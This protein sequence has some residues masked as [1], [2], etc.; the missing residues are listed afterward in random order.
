MSKNTPPVIEEIKLS[1]LVRDLALSGRS[2][3]EINANAKEKWQELEAFGGW[4]PHQPGQYF[5]RGGK[6]H[7]LVGFSRVQAGLDHGM[8]SGYFVEVPDDAS[9]LRVAC[10]SSNSGRNISQ[11]EQGRVYKAMREGTDRETA[12]AGDPVFAPMKTQE[13]ADFPGIGK[14]RQHV[15][16]CIAIFENPAAIAELI[17]S[18]QISAQVAL[19]AA[20]LCKDENKRLAWIKKA[21]KSAQSENKEIATLKHLDAHRADYAPLKA[22]PKKDETPVPTQTP[23]KSEKTS[24]WPLGS[25]SR[26]RDDGSD[27][28]NEDS[29]KPAKDIPQGESDLFTSGES[30]PSGTPAPNKFTPKK[31]RGLIAETVGKWQDALPYEV[32]PADCERL[33][34][35]LVKLHLP[36]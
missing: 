11:Y 7:L 20:Q 33:V 27:G 36:F 28:E 21:M 16:N 10:I 24:A 4:D 3:K 12:K 22:A 13:I 31:L 26:V 14:S 5:K 23:K 17:E 34:E 6:N 8:K 35:E 1:T 29:P 32:P 15:E 30:A 18:G 25:E 9:N 2:E 19:K